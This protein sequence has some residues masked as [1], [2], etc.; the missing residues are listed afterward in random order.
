MAE[1]RDRT[2]GEI[3]SQSEWKIVHSNVSTPKIWNE[4]TLNA[5]N[6]DPVLET[7]KPSDGINQYQHAI[8]NGATQDEN[9]NWV[10]AWQIVDMFADDDELGTKAEQE[11]AYQVEQD[12][13][14]NKINRI[15]RNDLLMQTDFYA[16]SDVTMSTE[17]QTYRQALRDITTHSNWPH[18]QGS[19]WP[20][21]P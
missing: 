1:Y 21:K 15:Y 3:K 2:T 5:L 12:N 14:A 7:P 11:A 13:Y 8:K 10:Q 19:D 20:T 16:L 9:G 17:M 4:D 6:L 18:L